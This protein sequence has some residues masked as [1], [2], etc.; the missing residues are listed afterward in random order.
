M[1]FP[2][3]TDLRN[4]AALYRNL[5]KIFYFIILL[6]LLDFLISFFLM[7]GIDSYYGLN[8]DS[9]ILLI[10]HSHLMLALDKRQLE[11]ITDLKVAKYTREG[12]NIKERD[13]MLKHY[14]LT[15]KKKPEY[16]IIGIDPWM[17]TEE[18]LSEN[19]YLL[20]LPF[21]DTPEVKDYIINSVQSQ[22]DF[23]IPKFIKSRRYNA[24]LINAS[25]R[26]YLGN[27]SNLK[28]GMIDSLKVAKEIKENNFR[29][30]SFNKELINDFSRMLENLKDVKSNVILLNTPVWAPLIDCQRREY[31]KTY[32]IIDS[33]IANHHLKVALVDLVP[34]FENSS[35]LFFD[36]IHMNPDGQFMV[37]AYFS[38]LLNGMIH[39]GKTSISNIGSN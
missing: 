33:L 39:R 29:R 24:L 19:S 15:C 1:R 4:D 22:K 26:G 32:S 38:G 5:R 11:L 21:M 10:G 17:F 3:F 8:G 2:L 12:V 16:I 31:E 25:M 23:L 6:F 36:P 18:G 13:L 28:F 34:R 7:T 30:I 14:L 27:W 37:T 20:F 35:K 9:Q